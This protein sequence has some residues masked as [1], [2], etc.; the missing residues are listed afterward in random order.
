MDEIEIDSYSISG[1]KLR[2]SRSGQLSIFLSLLINTS[3]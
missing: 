3:Y 2:K 1:F